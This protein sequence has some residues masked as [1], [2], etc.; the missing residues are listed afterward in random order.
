MFERGLEQAGLEI[1]ARDSLIRSHVGDDSSKTTAAK[2]LTTDQLRRLAALLEQIEEP[3]E[4]LERRGISLR[5]L[6]VDH[7]TEDGSLPRYRIFLGGE[8]HWQ[9]KM[10]DVNAFLEEHQQQTGQE[11]KTAD[12]S[13][14]ASAAAPSPAA[15]PQAGDPASTAAVTDLHEIRTINDVIRALR[16]EFQLSLNDLLPAPPKNAEAVFP[17]RITGQETPRRL[18]SLRE[19]VPALRDLGGKGLIYTRF[20]GL[21][22]M[23]PDELF[24]TAMDPEQRILKQVQLEDAAAAEEIFRV[25]MGDHV[26]PRREF[27]EKH[28]LE[29]QDLDI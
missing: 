14:I 24:E 19:L 15:T 4:A 16:E 18:Q 25:L 22:E 17:Y 5:R 20:K 13:L 23:N 2:V 27:I 8:E 9:A 3:I 29:V 6:S 11:T 26:E 7:A 10:T 12:P 1:D 21:G 28:A